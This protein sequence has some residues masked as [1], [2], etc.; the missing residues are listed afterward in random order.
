MIFNFKFNNKTWGLLL[1]ALIFIALV[2]VSKITEPF[3]SNPLIESDSL[4]PIRTTGSVVEKKIEM[5]V[6][7][8]RAPAQQLSGFIREFGMP[9][10]IDVNTSGLALWKRSTL[11]QRGCCWDKV[12]LNDKPLSFVTISYV[13]PLLRVR[14]QVDYPQALDTLAQFHPAVFFDQIT[15]TI[16][17][18]ANSLPLAVVLLVLAKRLLNKE[19]TLQQVHNLV[20]SMS[21]SIDHTAVNYDPD[22]YDKYKIELC[23][24]GLPQA[25]CLGEISPSEI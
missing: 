23:S 12:V 13:F 6:N 22:A 10:L 20:G 24:F 15:Q 25:N 18:K 7:W 21:S 1:I 9:D 5:Q 16:N 3:V 8:N 2:T 19:L 11:I 4:R 14:G 17:A